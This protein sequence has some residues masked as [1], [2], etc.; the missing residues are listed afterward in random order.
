MIVVDVRG[1]HSTQVPFIADD[2]VIETVSPDGSDQPLDVGILPRG[3]CRGENLFK[4]DP[5]NP[6]PER[7]AVDLVPVAQ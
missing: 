1:E 7:L 2:H 5:C 6:L 4:A 3:S